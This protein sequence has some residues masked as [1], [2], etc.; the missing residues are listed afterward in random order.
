MNGRRRTTE[1]YRYNMLIYI[2]DRSGEALPAAVLLLVGGTPTATRR[3]TADAAF[4]GVVR[5]AAACC[6]LQG[7]RPWGLAVAA[8]RPPRRVPLAVELRPA[9]TAPEAKY[10]II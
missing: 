1:N 3:P 6:N 8:A 2:Y 7:P 9:G 4:A 10:A 5:P